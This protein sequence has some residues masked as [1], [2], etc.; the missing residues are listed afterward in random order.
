[1]KPSTLV[2]TTLAVAVA[3]GTGS[4][5]SPRNVGAWYS[6]LPKPSYQPP[7]AAFPIVWTAL[8]GDIAT[9]S[10]VTIDKFR[11]TGQHAKARRYAAALSVNLLLNAGW[12]WLFFR[13]HK[14][15]ASALGAAALTVSSADLARR[16]AAADPR[17][18][19]ALSPYPLWCAF[20]TVL[21]THIWR[22]N[23][24]TQ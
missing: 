20:A 6:R 9:T 11:A 12:S 4:I 17:A 16:A 23:R 5:A 18:G 13:F 8:Y 19:K 21:S 3:A 10:A 22:L 7:G 2:A 15:G 14:L 24:R 1:M